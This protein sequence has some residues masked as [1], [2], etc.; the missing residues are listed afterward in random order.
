LDTNPPV[1]ADKYR[2]K[3]ED[4]NGAISYSNIVTLIYGNSDNANSSNISVYPNPASSVLNLAINQNSENQSPGLSA[5]QKLSL[6]PGINP[7]AESSSFGIKIISTAGSVIKSATSSQP[8]WQD[9]I[10][11][12]V[13]GT[14]IIQVVNNSDNSVVGKSTFVKL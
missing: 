11:S 10:S 12:L 9:N 7:S 4:M 3:I 1:G 14:Y 5:L 2:L 6:T 13:P 8:T